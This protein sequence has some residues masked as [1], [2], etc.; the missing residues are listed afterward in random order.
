M[1]KQL[2]YRGNATTCGIFK[3]TC[4]RILRYPA[5]NFGTQ[6]ID[7]SQLTIELTD[8]PREKIP[9]AEL[10]F[11]TQF[12]D[13]MLEID[14]NLSTGWEAPRISKFK[15]FEI[16]PAA[17][18]FHYAIECFEGMKAYKDSEGNI[19]LFRPDKNLSRLSNSMKRM[20]MPDLNEEA[21]LECMSELLHVDST[22][23]PEEEGY[24]LYIRPTAIGTHPF[25]GVGL[26][27][28][29]KLYVILSPVGPYYPDGFK[30][31]ELFADTENV[32]AWPGGVGNTK[33]GGNYGPTIHPQLQA[34]ER[35]YKQILW[36]F[37][38]DHTVTEV[39]SM[40][41]FFLIEKKYGN[42][43]LVTAPLSR[44]DILPGVTR[45]SVLTLA[46]EW[47]EFEVSERFITMKELLEC[48]QEGRLLESFGSGTAAIVCPVS[49]I[50][51]MG[52]DI[53]L[54]NGNSIGPMAQRFW[55]EI[56]SIQYGRVE[57]PWSVKLEKG[58]EKELI[59]NF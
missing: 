27:E 59:S 24:S 1:I 7:P 53:E 36:L 2:L 47:G 13:H 37:G 28:S 18:A 12:T 5:S 35:G 15:N 34:G 14:W 25:L 55:D 9:N 3:L 43:E 16:S 49:V 48:D 45:D 17:S 58:D 26:S 21:F 46:R 42:L 29:I 50:H 4:Q 38:E 56:T 8:A 41:L 30:P 57:H 52:H 51:Y 39:G 44:G 32:R 23:I 6:S 20:A 22:W 10:K 54:P 33:V 31:V 11:G 19:R 40:N